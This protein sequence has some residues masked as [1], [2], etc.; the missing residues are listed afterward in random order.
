MDNFD[1]FWHNKAMSSVRRWMRHWWETRTSNPYHSSNIS[2]LTTKCVRTIA[3]KL[4]TKCGQNKDGIGDF[5]WRVSYC[6]ELVGVNQDV[7]WLTLQ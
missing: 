2:D 3:D 4:L 5:T 7:V 1:E 6:E